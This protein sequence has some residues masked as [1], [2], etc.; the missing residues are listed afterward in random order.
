MKFWLIGL[1]VILTYVNPS[2]STPRYKKSEIA[3]ARFGTEE[4]AKLLKIAQNLTTQLNRSIVGQESA[5]LSLQQR[6]VQYLEGFPGRVH[7]PIS[8]HMIGLPGVGKSAMIS[9]LRDA[10]FKVV[11]FDA[12]KYASGEGLFASDVVNSTNSFI[13]EKRPVILVIEE[14]D[15]IKEVRSGPLGTEETSAFIGTLNQ[16]L[17]DGVVSVGGIQFPMSNVFVI[18]TMNFSPDHISEF[19]DEVLNGRKSY[20]DLT[21]AD[22]DQFIT[23]V[24]DSPGAR[25]KILSKLFRTNTVGRIAPNTIIMEPIRKDSY[26]LIAEMKVKE[27]IQKTTEGKNSGKRVQVSFDSSYVDFLLAEAVYAPSGARETVFR[28]D[29]LTEQ[30]INYGIK[31]IQ[32][33]S[34]PTDT[35]R[36]I[37]I[38]IDPVLKMAKIA[39]TP[40]VLR[41]KVLQDRATFEVSSLYDTSSKMFTP[42]ALIS[43]SK[44][45]YANNVKPENRK[46]TLKMVKENRFP[47]SLDVAKGLE[48]AIN[49]K[50]F[51]QHQMA[52]IIKKDFDRFLSR[53]GPA[54]KEP[55]YRILS[56]FPGLGK[57]EAV[58][59]VAKHLDLPIIKVNMQ[60]FSSDS[61]DVLMS[62]FETVNDLLVQHNLRYDKK[63]F[64][65]L[66]EELDKVF[67]IDPSGNVVNRP[68]M[69]VIKDL[70]NEGHVSLSGANGNKR[71]IDIRHA[72][73]FATMN[74]SVDRFGFEA[75]PRLTNTEDVIRAW[76]K[77]SAT[78]MATKSLL[79]SM[80]LPETVSRLMS[81]FSIFK[82]LNR[83]EYIQLV[84]D[85]L[86]IVADQRFVDEHGRNLARVEIEATPRYLDYLFGET[87]VPSEGAR[88]T[89][90]TAGGLIGNNLEEVFSRIPKNS[91]YSTQP[92]VITLDY[93]PSKKSFV[94][95][96]RIAHEPEPT[97]ITILEQPLALNFPSLK[98]TGRISEER[99]LTSAHEFG[100]AFLAARLG[101]RFETVVVA[102]PKPGIGGYVKLKGKRESAIDLMSNIYS[103][104]G[105]RAFER[106]V[107]SEDPMA[108]ESVMDITAGASSDIVQASKTLHQMI[109]ELG[110]DPWGGV[111]DRNFV[112]GPFKYADVQGLSDDAAYKMSLILRE[113]EDRIVEDLLETQSLEW[114]VERIATLARKGSLVET[115]FYDLIGYEHPGTSNANYGSTSELR[116]LFKRYIAAR[117]TDPKA[118]AQRRG[119]QRA[120]TKDSTDKYLKWFADAVK[121]HLHSSQSEC[122]TLLK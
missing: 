4:R 25:Y 37:S 3:D 41:G 17:S 62:F 63:P 96:I 58:K 78:P 108:K 38:S 79:G 66:I 24:K 93:L 120:T 105:A 80:F 15:K 1:I 84:K 103:I 30:L 20:Y 112:S 10:G 2:L 70:L 26:R 92:L 97:A 5:T 46:V 91:K 54:K 52:A 109:Y 77:I 60:Q 90:V 40:L 101:I 47:K 9:V 100:H 14:L 89:V 43:K 118:G 121:K 50:L 12:Q 45:G 27:A 73:T 39:I 19:T 59:I 81:R 76:K 86:R 88:H 104:L 71:F 106:L 102:S 122:E 23:W 53:V 57:S 82:P 21:M 6:L 44:P 33:S 49:E 61:S 22:L 98:V 107:L 94:G 28:S 69:G 18:T 29:T 34:T 87:V 74:F 35:P 75:D 32:D 31:A 11:H 111:I 7:E 67:E 113:M 64:I 65:L 95:K 85:Q 83:A 99:L 55:S 51:G 72:F 13:N 110:F 115:E 117:G 36:K 48:E 42:P 68:I 8:L 114:Y 16:I 119:D 56:G 116:R